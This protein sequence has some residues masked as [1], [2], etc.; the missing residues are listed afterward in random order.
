LKG[1]HR[2]MIGRQKL[3][4]G[5]DGVSPGVGVQNTISDLFYEEL[6]P[7]FN[8][9]FDE[10]AADQYLISADRIDID[11]GLL[12][13]DKWK[14]ELIDHVLKKLKHELI[15]LDKKRIGSGVI[16]EN[17]QTDCLFY[18]EH[19]YLPWNSSVHS[20]DV[21]EKIDTDKPFINKLKTLL[22]TKTQAAERM[23]Y[24]LPDPSR[25]K[26]IR[27]LMV[28]ESQPDFVS[29][30]NAAVFKKD[31]EAVQLIIEMI[32]SPENNLR[33][34]PDFKK[35]N[36]DTSVEILHSSDN[37]SPEKESESIYIDN[38]GLVILHP[39]LPELF[40]R[41]GFWRDK[42]WTEP[43]YL[44]DAAHVLAYL[45]TG[46]DKNPEFDM[47]LNKIMCG[48]KTSDVLLPLSE[49]SEFVKTECDDLL[50]EV[51]RHWTRLKNTSIGALRETFLQ[52]VGKLTRTDHGWLLQIE[53]KGVDVLLGSLPWGIGTIK[54]PWTDDKLFVEW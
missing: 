54:L 5:F 52:R 48:I 29:P 6:V 43:G 39:F 23:V 35:E 49:L 19:G 42:Q 4:I 53:R 21:F 25:G 22:L 34:S 26:L 10:L 15:V 3:E 24:Q 40:S 27:S 32:S 31:A 20:M 51:V 44:H 11:C 38:A 50:M 45:H 47:I 16:Q 37:Q 18:L 7:K 28:H 14:D 17:L 1:N 33:F 13:A 30:V 8:K 9:L 2:H 41:L 36:G 12:T 46:K